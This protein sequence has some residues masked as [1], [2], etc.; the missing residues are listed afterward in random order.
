MLNQATFATS[1]TTL[2]L[3][4]FDDNNSLQLTLSP[5]NKAPDYS[6]RMTFRHDNVNELIKVLQ[7]FQSIMITNQLKGESNNGN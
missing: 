1:F 7:I 2:T 3:E 5:S 4:Y 6:M